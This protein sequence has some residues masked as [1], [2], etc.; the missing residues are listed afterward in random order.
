MESRTP[1]AAWPSHGAPPAFGPRR[2]TTSRFVSALALVVWMTSGC[3]SPRVV[4]PAAPVVTELPSYYSVEYDPELGTP[5][6]IQNQ[7]AVGSAQ[8]GAPAPFTDAEAL[9][10]VRQFVVRYAAVFKLRP[11]YDDFVAIWAA[12]CDGSNCLKI[13]QTYR[14][15][16]VD[17]MGYGVSVLPNGEVGSM[18]GRFTPDLQILTRPLVRSTRAGATAVKAL[19]PTVVGLRSEPTLVIALVGEGREPHL[20]WSAVVE[21]P[22]SFWSWTV[23]VD[24][25]SGAV[26]SVAPN[27]IVN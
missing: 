26:L 21:T 10:I 6:L 7:H 9:L 8:P 16:P 11:K 15:L 5:R 22:G 13:Q 12:S 25:L 1:R 20:A 4:G 3:D 17:F 23:R 19:L 14:G 18:V 27:F 2:V 24:A